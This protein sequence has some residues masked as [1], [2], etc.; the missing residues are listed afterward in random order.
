MLSQLALFYCTV[1]GDVKRG[2]LKGHLTV[3][4]FKVAQEQRR[5]ETLEAAKEAARSEIAGLQDEKADALKGAEDAKARMNELAPKLK[6]RKSQ[7]ADGRY[8]QSPAIHLS[9]LSRSAA[10]V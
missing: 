8:R 4:Q 6:M 9:S 10:A 5:L 3:T 2:I 1:Y 7:V